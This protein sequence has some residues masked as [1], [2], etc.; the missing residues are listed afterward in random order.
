MIFRVLTDL[1]VVHIIPATPLASAG[2]IAVR[3]V[4]MLVGANSILTEAFIPLCGL[5][6][7]TFMWTSYLYH[8]LCSED[9]KFRV[10]SVW[11]ENSRAQWEFSYAAVS[12]C[13]R[14]S[15]YKKYTK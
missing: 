15:V 7:Y 11:G 9:H 6:I 4:V 10:V 2:V 14:A 5:L 13:G 12:M 1:F 3:S 8:M